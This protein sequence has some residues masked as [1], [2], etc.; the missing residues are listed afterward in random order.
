M[1]HGKSFH[2]SAGMRGP[3]AHKS[4]FNCLCATRRPVRFAERTDLGLDGAG[5]QLVG[6]LPALLLQQLRPCCVL[7][8]QSLEA[9]DLAQLVADVC[10]AVPQLLLQQ[11]DLARLLAHLRLDG[12]NYEDGGI[13]TWRA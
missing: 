1:Q 2:P 3:V 13:N 10:L 9:D 7:L 12:G 8:Q 6:V 4:P 11:R 5:V